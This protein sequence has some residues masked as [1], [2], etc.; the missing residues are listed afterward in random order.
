MSDGPDRPPAFEI[1]LTARAREMIFRVVG[2]PEW[3][4]EGTGRVERVRRRDGLPS[5]VQPHVR[6]TSVHISSHLKAWLGETGK[7]TAQTTR[8][9]DAEGS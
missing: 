5:R 4:T 7:G 1:K 8:S 2:E 3:H 9:G 6:Y